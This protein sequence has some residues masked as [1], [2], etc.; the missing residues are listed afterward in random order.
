VSHSSQARRLLTL[1]LTVVGLAGVGFTWAKVAQTI[2]DA[3]PVGSSSIRPTAI[4][5]DDR[6][7]QTPS[8]LRRWLRSRG[9][10]YVEWKR[11]HPV[12]NA[13]VEH[14]PVRVSRPRPTVSPHSAVRVATSARGSGFPVRDVSL[15]I[16]LV[17]LIACAVAAALP[18]T[19]AYRFPAVAQR[20]VPHRDLL[21]A[22]AAALVVGLVIGT[23]LT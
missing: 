2:S 18:G 12:A 3:G 16:V 4:A 11:K 22:S 7:F 1:L 14:R 19:V 10:D 21:L 5:W 20:V 6:V 17:L 8:A 23:A 9:V 13:L 15:A